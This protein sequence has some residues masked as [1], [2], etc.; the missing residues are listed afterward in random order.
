MFH[1][2]R[3]LLAWSSVRGQNQAQRL[4]CCTYDSSCSEV[5]GSALPFCGLL[6]GAFPLTNRSVKHLGCAPSF[7]GSHR[8]VETAI[9]THPPAQPQLPILPPSSSHLD[10]PN[11][12]SCIAPYLHRLSRCRWTLESPVHDRRRLI[13]SSCKV[14]LVPVLNLGAYLQCSNVSG[15]TQDPDFA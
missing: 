4:T 7:L 12:P 5:R 2:C 11:L 14:Q 10:L 13:V 8:Q 1:S 15:C 3:I 9:R 6:I